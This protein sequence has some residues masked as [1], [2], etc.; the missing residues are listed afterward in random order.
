MKALDDR[1]GVEGFFCIVRST[2]EFHFQ[3]QWY[4]TKPALEEY[5]KTAVSV[6]K[7]WDTSEVGAKLEAFAI[8]KCDVTSMLQFLTSSM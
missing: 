8:A 5:M 1:V 7:A 6:R 4:F 2:T 3:P